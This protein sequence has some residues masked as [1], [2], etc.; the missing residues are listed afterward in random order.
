MK[1]TLCMLALMM[2]SV[3]S[4]WAF[5]EQFK[6]VTD[7]D[8]NKH[9]R[10][11][12]INITNER[13]P[14]L[15]TYT[16][17]PR[18]DKKD[19]ATLTF[20]FV[21]TTNQR[22]IDLSDCVLAIS[23][24]LQGAGTSKVVIALHLSN[25][26]RIYFDGTSVGGFGKQDWPQLLHVSRDRYNTMTSFIMFPLEHCWSDKINL[27]SRAKKRYKY[28]LDQLSKFD[29]VQVTVS[30]IYAN[31]NLSNSVPVIRPTAETFREM[32]RRGGKK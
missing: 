28:V 13:D 7:D 9:C 21:R 29:I 15:C 2:L 19:N 8:G 1:R 22:S 4:G 10:T 30:D 3:A 23:R 31:I 32:L 11:S 26:E 27:S 18:L 24:D 17:A 12:Q 25:G 20:E 6:V 14:L 5:S 16:L